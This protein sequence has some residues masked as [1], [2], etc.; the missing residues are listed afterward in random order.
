MNK[1]AFKKCIIT[2]LIKKIP[3][4]KYPRSINK[5]VYCLLGVESL[6]TK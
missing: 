6:Q 4:L 1:T 5:L 3:D 2:M